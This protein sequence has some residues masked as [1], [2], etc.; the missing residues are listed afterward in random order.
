MA[1]VQSYIPRHVAGGGYLRAVCNVPD[2]CLPRALHMSRT[3]VTL[4]FYRTA[5]LLSSE[6]AYES[7]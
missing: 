6:V 4:P 2:I 7:L 1:S 3:P 5:R